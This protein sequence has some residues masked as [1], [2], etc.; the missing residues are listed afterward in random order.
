MFQGGLSLRNDSLGAFDL[1]LGYI[2]FSPCNCQVAVGIFERC[3]RC[4]TFFLQSLLAFARA[5][6]L[7]AHGLASRQGCQLIGQSGLSRQ[8][9]GARL[10][11]LSFK[12]P[13][14]DRRHDVASFDFTIEINGEFV[15]LTG[16]LRSDRNRHK[17]PHRTRGRDEFADRALRDFDTIVLY[18]RLRRLGGRQHPHGSQPHCRQG[19]SKSEQVFQWLGHRHLKAPSRFR[20]TR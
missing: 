14:V 5:L 20:A 17:G 1:C 9:I 8:E 4:K 12:R 3:R 2:N 18:A 15:D 11:N 13:R 7:I 19:H 16:Q 10:R 6:C